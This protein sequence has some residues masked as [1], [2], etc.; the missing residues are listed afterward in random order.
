MLAPVSPSMRSGM[1]GVVHGAKTTM[2]GSGMGRSGASKIGASAHRERSSED[3]ERAQR[4]CPEHH[5]QAYAA[6]RACR[7]APPPIA[8]VSQESR[9]RGMES[10]RT[11]RE[12]AASPQAVRTSWTVTRRS[13]G[14]PRPGVAVICTEPSP[15][16]LARVRVTDS[17]AA[18]RGSRGGVVPL[19][20]GRLPRHGM[21]AMRR[22]RCRVPV[23]HGQRAG[24]S[25]ARCAVSRRGCA[26]R[27]HAGAR[28][29]GSVEPAASCRFDTRWAVRDRRSVRH[30]RGGGPRQEG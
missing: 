21:A 23:A 19:P 17:A 16:R 22:A 10:G 30:L 12:G 29:H 26:P 1:S 2:Y 27:R 8:D 13:E 18:L 14:V 9:G 4:C 25:D 11:S 5:T 24:W 28:R 6:G 3:R 20:P 7:S 15:R